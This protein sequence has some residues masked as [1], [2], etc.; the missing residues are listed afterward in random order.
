MTSA[1]TKVETPKPSSLVH[2]GLLVVNSFW[3]VAAGILLAGILHFVVVPQI[4]GYWSDLIINCGIAIILAVSLTVVNGL[5]G[6]FSIGHAGFMSLGGYLA[7]SIVYYGSYR[8]F[9]DAVFRGGILSWTGPMH[10]RGP[11]IGSGDLLFLGA[12]LAG[13]V[14]AACVG[15]LVGLPSLR[16]R[17]DYLAIVTLGFGEIVRVVIQGTPDQLDAYSS[18][19]SIHSLPFAALLI[20]LGGALGFSGAPAY[21]SV[22]WVILFTVITLAATIRL[23]YSSY[24]RALLS[25][26]EDEIAARA[27]GVNT[28]RFK[29]RA[30]MFSA[31]FAGAAGALYAMKIGTINA[32]DLGF[33]KSF[34]IIIMVVLGG[35]GSVSGAAIAAI[36]L[37]LLPE[38]L[39]NPPD[40]W[41]WGLVGAVIIAVLILL[42]APR[43]KG[44]LITLISVCAAWEAMRWGANW[45]GIPLSDYRMVIYALALIVMMILRPEGL[46]GLKEIWDYLPRRKAHATGLGSGA[47]PDTRKNPYRAEITGPLLDMRN[48]SLSFGGLKAVQDFSLTLPLGGLYG[49]IGP[50]GAGKT[51]AFNLL[52]GVY[53]PTTGSIRLANRDITR[54]K[55]NRIARAGLARTFQNIRLFSELTVL[56]NV[57]IA[58]Q[59][60]HHFGIWSTTFRTPS[61]L[62]QERQILAESEHLLE[63]FG[64]SDRRNEQAKNLPYGDQRRLEIARA[65]ATR[66]RVLLLDEPAA[67]MNP[68]EKMELM[69]LIR[70]IRDQ[71]HVGI[72]LIEHDMKLVM[73]ICQQITVLDHGETIAVGTPE[74]IQTNPRVI[75]AYLGD[76]GEEPGC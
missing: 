6:Q 64:L 57:R 59:L 36:L 30:F 25:V 16:L 23:K 46:F 1:K 67:G 31:F 20:H 28:T 24:G 49:L 70:F 41:P 33:M 13:G 21:S 3:P 11:L 4:G 47:G 73:N 53:H 39:R 15:W 62:K 12:C 5:A 72:L 45:L 68:Q 75:E 29:V 55:P 50:N 63:I 22:F 66:P 65:L 56:D 71:F 19:P 27:C 35:M 17:G 58:C 54:R 61:C 51:T 44:P 48:V 60:R 26:R 37:T 2:S 14:L 32:T 69:E 18:S 40:L 52:T 10:A 7:A 42:M 76:G 9:G 38:L 8:L 74:E 43:K 34:D